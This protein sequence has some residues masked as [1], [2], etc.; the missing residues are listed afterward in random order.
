MDFKAEQKSVAKI[1]DAGQKVASKKA[2]GSPS[3]PM[4]FESFSNP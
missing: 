4:A 3:E 1:V 2:I